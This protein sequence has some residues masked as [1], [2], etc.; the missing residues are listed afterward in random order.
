MNREPSL[1]R[2]AVCSWSLQP[3]RPEDLV[4][5]VCA[6]GINRVQLALDPIRETPSLW[7]AAS[8]LLRQNQIEIVSGMF[9][10]VGE[11]YSTL[12]TIRS[13]GGIAPDATW[14]RNLENIRG[15][16]EIATRLRLRLVTF[17]AGFLPHDK[18]A[19]EFSKMLGRLAEL[20]EL[21]AARDLELGLETGQE[22]ALA[23]ATLLNELN[24]PNVG[25]NFDPANMILYGK[26]DPVEALR[27]LKPW[28][29]QIHLKDAKPAVV[30]GTWGEEVPLGEGQ[31][32]WPKFFATLKELQFGG[33][34]VIEREAGVQRVADVR[35]AREVFVKLVH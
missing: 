12:E 4:A 19:P 34:C 23:L 3:T 30:P 21:F 2:L 22:S 9:G 17:H 31:V 13:T 27:I 16:V 5:K 29:R 35:T 6:C 33:D 26:G 28:L 8:E 15:I 20:A 11:D 32:D 25:V 1:Q 24:R 10:C 7:G 14:N 18:S